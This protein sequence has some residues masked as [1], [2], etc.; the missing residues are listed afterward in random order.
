MGKSILM[1][2]L[3]VVVA[4]GFFMLTGMF[5]HPQSLERCMVGALIVVMTI[6]NLMDLW[7]VK[8]CLIEHSLLYHS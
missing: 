4:F 7:N 1:F 5:H 6:N 2:V 3:S 8:Q